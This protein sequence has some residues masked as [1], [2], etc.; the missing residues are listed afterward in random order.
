[1]SALFHPSVMT[2]LNPRYV[3]LADAVFARQR[4]LRFRGRPNVFDVLIGN[5]PVPMS[6]SALGSAPS[7]GVGVVVGLCAKLKMRRINAWRVIASVPDDK[8]IRD[9]AFEKLV[10]VPV[11]ADGLSA[12]EQENSITVCVFAALPEPASIGFFDAAFKNIFRA[13]NWMLVNSSSPVQSGVARSAKLSC[14]RRS[15]WMTNAIQNVFRLISH[16][17]SPFVRYYMPLAWSGQIVI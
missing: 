7:G 10:R 1:M 16:L 2:R 4:G 5:A 9:W 13:K 3:G 12:G 15:A 8:A 17:A 6:G 14:D 11:R